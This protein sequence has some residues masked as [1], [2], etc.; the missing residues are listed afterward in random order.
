M[1]YKLVSQNAAVR[2]EDDGSS[3]FSCSIDD[4]EYVK[5]ISDGNTPLPLDPPTPSDILGMAEEHVSQYFS[6]MRLL[7][8]KV[9]LDAA[10]EDVS[11]PKLAAVNAWLT[12]VTA[13]AFQGDTNF[14][15]PPHTFEEV[16]AEAMS[17]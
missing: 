5:W 10:S 1:N 13:R 15:V 14:D 16:L 11:I 4:P 7:Q 12:S 3:H 17:L 6:S 2:L 8:M 9:W